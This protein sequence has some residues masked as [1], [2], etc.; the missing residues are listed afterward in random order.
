MIMDDTA[1]VAT[2]NAGASSE[3]EDIG[4]ERDD[5]EEDLEDSEDDV[6][7]DEVDS[8]SDEESKDN[9]ELHQIQTECTTMVQLLK[10]LEKEEHNLDCELE[11]LAR[12]A[13]L[14]GFAPDIVEPA[15][16]RTR[17]QRRPRSTAVKSWMSAFP[18]KENPATATNKKPKTAATEKNSSP[19]PP[20]PTA[21]TT[22]TTATNSAMATGGG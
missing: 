8:L 11:I 22:S 17:Q 4:I 12:E 15:A 13:L 21:A 7:E 18:T 3:E 1:A 6:D 10:N 2:A 5:E 20:A 9:S 16:A 14:C 19:P